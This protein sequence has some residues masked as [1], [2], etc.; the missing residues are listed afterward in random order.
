LR[1]DKRLYDRLAHDPP[2]SVR[3]HLQ[4]DASYQDGLIGSL[5]ITTSR[6]RRPRSPLHK[7][8]RRWS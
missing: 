7:R 1:Y 2:E 4:A 5:R 3:E 6:V 8:A